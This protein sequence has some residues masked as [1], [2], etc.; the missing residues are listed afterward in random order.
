MTDE[1]N[2][3]TLGC[4]RE[5][6]ND[7][8]VW[9]EGVSVKT[10][11]IDSLAR[12]GAI[13]TNF[14]TVAPLCTPSRASF[15]SGLYPKFT[16]AYRN[17]LAMN[18]DV[19]TF[20]DLL[21]KADYHTGYVGKW[22]LDGDEKPGFS[23]EKKRFGFRHNKYQFNRG[24]W[25]LF[26]EDTETGETNVYYWEDRHKVKGEM[27]DT[28]VT[29]FLFGKGI[30]FMEKQIKKEKKFALMLSIPDPHG[31]NKIRPPY[32]TMYNHL[33]FTL[34]PTAVAAYHRKP[35]LPGW[36]YSKVEIEKADETI[37]SIEN[38][39]K[40]QA[41]MR[42]YFGMVKLIDDKVGEL[43]SFLE[44]SGQNENTI[45]VF[46]SDHGDMMGEHGRYN[47]GKPY[48]SSAGVPFIIRYPGR[49]IRKVINTAHSSTDFA[50]T[51]L[52][53]MG[54]DHSDTGFQGTDAS[55]EILSNATWSNLEQVRFMTDSSNKSNWAAAVDRQ[56]KL[57]LSKS[58]PPWL[59][60][61]KEDP[62][63]II[64]YSTNS[65][66]SG[67]M[68]KLQHELTNAIE[69]YKFPLSHIDTV[70][71]NQPVCYDTRDQIP[72]LPYHVC[73]DLNKAQYKEK[74]DI[75]SVSK[76]CPGSCGICCKDSIESLLHEGELKTCEDVKNDPYQNCEVSQ[77]AMFCPVTCSKC[78]PK[79]S[80]T[81]SDT[82]TRKH[83][84]ISNIPTGSPT[85]LSSSISTEPSAAPSYNP[86]IEPSSIPSISPTMAPGTSP[87]ASPSAAPS[88]IPSI[89]PSSIPSISPTMAP[90]TSPSAFP[91]AVPSCSPSS[92]PTASPSIS[93]S[94][95]ITLSSSIPTVAPA[96]TYSS[97]PA[98]THPYTPV[99][100]HLSPPTPN[101]S[102][103]P[104]PTSS[105]TPSFLIY[106]SSPAPT[107]PSTPATTH[108]SRPPNDVQFILLANRSISYTAASTT[109]I[110]FMLTL[111]LCVQSCR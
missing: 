54:I 27:K 106:S 80:T 107:R 44:K 5:I 84:Q 111:H 87:S 86:T 73:D 28:Y 60:D 89:E 62:N 19:V 42:N 2:M 65:S 72:D 69:L 96:Q 11:N 98:S 10:P 15:M 55:D 93:P 18:D 49:V 92:G 61:L 79:S 40:W 90:S 75:E 67:I 31:P 7:P 22:H 74:C 103:T 58:A 17:H 1:H 43:L 38:D 24:H 16:G 25:K 85:T 77:I 52:G 26:E 102:S 99:P 45:I 4:Y 108:P 13:F 36:A 34:P 20:A 46:T 104:S 37:I 81:P 101:R 82:P 48:L 63:E 71:L 30:E 41:T 83:T 66:Y 53:L 68:K 76:F 109:T 8:F 35:A 32:D 105:S 70:Y 51:I 91:S 57:V 12:D 14:N 33:N 29:D 94:N 59:F 100:T 47:K 6:I 64:N 9:G 50:P 110:I 78:I 97:A 88:N 3:R 21:H 56:Y 39:D 95:P 23:K